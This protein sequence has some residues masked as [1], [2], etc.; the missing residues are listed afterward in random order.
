M[1]TVMEL[2]NH[3]LDPEESPQM[4]EESWRELG[5]KCR[6]NPLFCSVLSTSGTPRGQ[7]RGRKRKTNSHIRFSDTE[8]E[9]HRSSTLT[10]VKD[11]LGI[12][13]KVSASGPTSD[14]D[15][16]HEDITSQSTE[17]SGECREAQDG[18][19]PNWT[20]PRPV[21]D[22]EDQK[23]P[24]DHRAQTKLLW[25]SEADQEDPQDHGALTKQRPEEDQERPN[26]HRALPSLE[27]PDFLQPQASAELTS[28][29]S[30]S[31][32]NI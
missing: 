21:E 29:E 14:C 31:A 10:K 20:K 25:R 22:Q 18:A 32:L 1:V 5:L 24:K 2:I 19:G 4:S 30:D 16:G 28:F 6:E 12:V 7:K 13:Q 3:E 17:T 27:T 9:S 26:N 11:F 8:S 15:P 23:D